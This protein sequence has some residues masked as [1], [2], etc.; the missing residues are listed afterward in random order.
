MKKRNYTS[1]YLIVGEKTYEQIK[2]L[3]NEN[4]DKYTNINNM[5]NSIMDVVESTKIET[6]EYAPQNEQNMVQNVVSPNS[7]MPNLNQ[8]TIPRKTRT[9][10]REFDKIGRND[11]CPCG[12]GKKYKNC[13]LKNGEYETHIE[14]NKD[15]AYKVADHQAQILSFRSSL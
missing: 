4:D 1:N 8:F 7:T 3:F 9:I 2:D 13:C 12:S 10:I 15:Q 14:L 11:P 5:Q 6:N